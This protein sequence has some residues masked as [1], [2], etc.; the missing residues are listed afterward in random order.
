MF[1][2]GLKL[3]FKILGIDVKFDLTFLL[4]LPLFTYLLGGR[5]PDYANFLGMREQATG[6]MGG[7]TPYLIGFLAASGLFLSVLVHEFGHALTARIFGVRTRSITLWLLGGLAA[8]ERIPEQRGAEAVVAIVGP[9]TS[10]ALAGLLALVYVAIPMDAASWVVA[11][12]IIVGILSVTNLALAIFNLIPALPLDG[13]RVLRSLLALVMDRTKATLAAGVV[14]KV[15]AVGLAFLAVAPLLFGGGGIDPFLFLVAIFVYFAVNAETRQTQ[16]EAML[17]G[18]K[19]GDLMNRSVVTV[20]PEMAVGEL[21]AMMVRER[22]LGFPVAGPDGRVI[23]TV[24]LRDLQEVPT[25][26][27]EV[28][29]VMNTDVHRIAEGAPAREAFEQMG[30]RGFGRMVVTGPDGAM[31]GI[32][33]KADLMRVIQIRALAQ[34]AAQHGVAQPPPLPPGQR[35]VSEPATVTRVPAE[36]VV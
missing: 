28:G 1:G 35:A 32:V 21:M 2:R 23:G 13:G 24:G 19:V 8:L 9:L 22:H 6:L 20:R 31:V 4:V 11:A 3:P 33:T 12:K 26:G 17:R 5:L 10:F 27:M 30:Q 14:S 25:E 7:Y 34:T 29:R 18:V 15:L 16:V 36:P